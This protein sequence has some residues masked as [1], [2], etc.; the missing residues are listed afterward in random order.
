[1]RVSL[2]VRW[3]FKETKVGRFY[4]NIKIHY[5]DDTILEKWTC[6]IRKI[7]ISL[8]YVMMKSE[9]T[10]VTSSCNKTKRQWWVADKT[11]WRWRRNQKVISAW[12]EIYVLIIK[13]GTKV[14][15]FYVHVNKLVD[16]TSNQDVWWVYIMNSKKS[17]WFKTD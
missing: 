16:W 6:Y 14:F 9:Q 12:G 13:K 17:I 1:M 11:R 15:L 3:M 8:I 10:F 5:E 7:W 4:Y 2:C